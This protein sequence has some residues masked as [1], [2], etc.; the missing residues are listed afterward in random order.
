M[1]IPHKG[2]HDWRMN[3]RGSA[4]EEIP[5]VSRC[6]FTGAWDYIRNVSCDAENIAAVDTLIHIMTSVE[7]IICQIAKISYS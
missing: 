1:L 7:S 3:T 5:T 2:I 4:W 6:H